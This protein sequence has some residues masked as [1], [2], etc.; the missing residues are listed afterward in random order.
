M[1]VLRFSDPKK[2]LTS[3]CANC[4]GRGWVY[5]SPEVMETRIAALEQQ[6]LTLRARC[7]MLATWAIESGALDPR[8]LMPGDLATSYPP[9]SSP[10][11]R[12]GRE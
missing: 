5:A 10:T 2:W 9:R 7:V 4:R 11:R 8:G 12:R 1:H 3:T 6:V